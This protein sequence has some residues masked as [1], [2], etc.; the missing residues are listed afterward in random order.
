MKNNYELSYEELL[1]LTNDISPHQRSLNSLMSY[2][3]AKMEFHLTL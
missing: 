2:T 3:N 1:D